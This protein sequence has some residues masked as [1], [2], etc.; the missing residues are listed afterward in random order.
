MTSS[1]TDPQ[2]ARSDRIDRVSSQLL[3]RVAVLTR[4]LASQLGCEL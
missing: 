3:P 1:S 2:R 4:L